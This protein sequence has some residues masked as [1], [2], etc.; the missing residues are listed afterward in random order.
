MRLDAVLTLVDCAHALRHLRPGA[1]SSAMRVSGA[2]GSAGGAG[3]GA[4]WAEQVAFADR[5]L[6]NKV[7]LVDGPTLASVRAA[8]R[9]I[10]PSATLVECERAA[11]PLQLLLHTHSFDAS[12][13]D[14]HPLLRD[15]G[16][17][18]DGG[19]GGGG[20][21]VS[22]APPLFDFSAP[23]SQRLGTLSLVVEGELDEARF[24]SW[25]FDLLQLRGEELLRMK[26]VLAFTG[27]DHALNFHSVH[28]TFEGQAGRAWEEGE[29]KRSR[30]V[31]IGRGLRREELK[32]GFE[33][34]R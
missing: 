33:G 18:G 29:Q 6:L 16:E 2:R 31:V 22:S 1:A 3:H 24:N 9:T 34:C 17:G 30:L 15:A 5:I 26:G 11:A 10:N 7:D 19:S 14:D 8:V 25:V 28:M 27:R 12:A 21:A 20:H 13:A 23:P 4:A 32:A